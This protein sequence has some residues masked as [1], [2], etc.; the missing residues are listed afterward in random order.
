M[1][2]KAASYHVRGPLAGVGSQQF[3]LLPR[4]L[5]LSAEIER[6][7]G[8]EGKLTRSP[9]ESGDRLGGEKLALVEE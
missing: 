8:I 7:V 5:A 2:N 3:L 1:A 6:A 9:M 4:R